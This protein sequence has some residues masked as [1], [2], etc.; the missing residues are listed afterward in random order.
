M[1]KEQY[2]LSGSQEEALSSLAQRNEYAQQSK[3]RTFRELPAGERWPYFRQHFAI[4]V[5]AVLLVVAAL[6]SL[7]VTRLNQ[8]PTP[9]LAVQ[10]FNMREY[11]GELKG[12]KAG[13]VQQE[14]IDDERL[15]EID[16]S[17]TYRWQ[18]SGR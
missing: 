13:F 15:I 8:P 5:M 2:G 7:V 9:V 16:A 10:A 18:G 12:L 3:W 11:A 1:A 6:V 14:G 17:F 4:G